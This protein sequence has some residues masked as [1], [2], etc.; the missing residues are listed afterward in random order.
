[1]RH[2]V[3]DLIRRINV[4]HDKAIELQLTVRTAHSDI[5]GKTYDKAEC[6]ALLKIS[7]HWHLVLL[8]TKKAILY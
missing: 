7:H 4:M 5:S 3:E 8:W 6:I 1:M 2:T